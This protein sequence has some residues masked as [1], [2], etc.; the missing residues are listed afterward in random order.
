M[1]AKT[2]GDGTWEEVVAP[3][4]CSY[5]TIGSYAPGSFDKCSDPKDSGSCVSGLAQHVVMSA[6]IGARGQRWDAGE[7]I[8]YVRSSAPL[9]LYFLR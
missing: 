8:T 4:D 2:K 5:Y 9:N 1:H 3:F 6:P 7:I